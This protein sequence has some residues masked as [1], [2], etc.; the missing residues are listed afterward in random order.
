[1]QDNYSVSFSP[2][3]LSGCPKKATSD[4]PDSLPAVQVGLVAIK[5]YENATVPSEVADKANTML[6]SGDPE[7]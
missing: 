1:M 5:L 3:I 4:I 2:P 6:R 7:A